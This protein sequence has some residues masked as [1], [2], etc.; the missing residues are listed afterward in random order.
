MP[1][2]RSAVDPAF[3]GANREYQPNRKSN[4]TFE[5]TQELLT[6]KYLA[7]FEERDPKRRAQLMRDYEQTRARTERILSA[8]RT[9]A[10]GG[11]DT[12]DE[13]NPRPGVLAAP[14]EPAARP[15]PEID[16]RRT[17]HSSARGIGLESWV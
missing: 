13:I 7:F 6:Q 14:R 2:Y 10:A 4:R 17:G 8:R 5:Q 15:R 9:R 1:Y 12:T 11:F 3:A 16:R